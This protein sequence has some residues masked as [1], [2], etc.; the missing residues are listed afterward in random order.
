LHGRIDNQNGGKNLILTGADFGRAYLSEGWAARFVTEL[1]REFTVVFVGYSLNDPVMGYLVDALAAERERGA[2]GFQQPFALAASPPAKQEA[3]TELWR[4]KGVEPVV[5]D[6]VDNHHLLTDTV[7]EWARVT[8]DPL[9]SRTSIALEGIR[10]LPVGP[11]DELTKRVVWALSYPGVAQALA[12]APPVTDDLEFPIF[13]AW[14]DILYEAGLL[15]HIEPPDA[16]P[17]VDSGFRAT[18]PPAWT[19]GTRHLAWWITRHLHIPQLIEWVL[20]QG[21]AL[22]PM[23]KDMVRDRLWRSNPDDVGVVPQLRLYW[24]ILSSPPHHVPVAYDLPKMLAKAES[25]GERAVVES[26]ALQALAPTLVLRPGPTAEV[27]FHRIMNTDAPEATPLE[28]CAHL[29]MILA[30]EGSTSLLGKLVEQL[31]SDKAFL[32]KNATQLTTLIRQALDLRAMT[33]RASWGSYV[34]RPSIADHDQ[35]RH[36]EAWTELIT[37]ARDGY[38]SLAEVSQ[39]QADNLIQTWLLDGRPIFRRM[40]LHAVTTDENSNIGVA[41]KILLSDA[42]AGLWDV[43]L[44]H[45][46]AVFLR[47]AAIRLD[48][49]A[50]TRLIAAILAGPPCDDDT[51][52]DVERKARRD[53]EIWEYL[54]KLARS[55]CDLTDEANA[56]MSD[57]ALRLNLK[58]NEDDS[59]EFPL[60][61]GEARW[62]VPGENLPAELRKSKLLEIAQSFEATGFPIEQWRDY[63]GLFPRRAFLVL[64]I[65]GRKGIWPAL[66]AQRA[67]WAIQTTE[68]E[69]DAR[70][71][72]LIAGLL[73]RAPAQ[74]FQ[75]AGSAIAG[76][77]EATA[78]IW[79]HDLFSQLWFDAWEASPAE[80]SGVNTDDVL[81]TAINHVAGKLAEAIL[82]RLW[83]RDPGRGSGLT[84]DEKLFL[85][86]IVD[87][88]AEGQHLGRVVL[89]RV[90]WNLHAIDRAWVNDRLLPFFQWRSPEGKQMWQAY[91]WNARLGPNLLADAK[92]LLLETFA[93]SSELGEQSSP[94]IQAFA[95]LTVHAP[96]ALR[97]D[98]IMDVVAHLDEDGLIVIL[99]WFTRLFTGPDDQRAKLWD[100]SIKLWIATYWPTGVDQNTAETAAIFADL[101]IETGTAF[102]RALEVIRPYLQPIREIGQIV[103]RLDDDENPLYQRAPDAVLELLDAITGNVEPYSRGMLTGFLNKIAGVFQPDARWHRLMRLAQG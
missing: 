82:R 3:S 4:S 79:P 57:I 25:D 92:E 100:D 85:D 15:G 47:T 48:Q 43:E 101:V 2:S 80:G 8:G 27:S 73:K 94:I 5:Y 45:E 37:L 35:N 81:T 98:E 88:A 71:D 102:P 41:E 55:G 58:P 89:A 66:H 74:V 62:V 28:E 7:V 13:V 56:T 26:E 14:L 87:G 49:G 44:N 86:A 84:G 23:M 18:N 65:L 31:L 69:R 33:D 59:D 67:L 10:K 30:G 63:A 50:R 61:C 76:W 21:G 91:A 16:A 12:E 64:A 46:V 29:E 19:S 36:R 52:T 51:E 93:R 38:V 1:F 20:R 99:R 22:H 60:W 53:S 54:E 34:Y 97:H 75:Q 77:L 39:A 96:D 42:G 40:A 70:L 17:I 78:T 11:H 72:K 103:W 32:S 83:K 24:Q 95:S 6:P 90:L 68:G 9:G